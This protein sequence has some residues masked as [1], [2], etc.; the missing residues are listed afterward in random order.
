MTE[1]ARRYVVPGR[2]ELVGKHVDYAGGRSLTCAVDRA[3]TVEAR[4][5]D[6]PMVRVRDASRRGVVQ[7]PLLAGVERTHRSARWSAYV[8]AVARR[9]ARDFPQA[10]SGVELHVSSTL[11]PSAGLSSSSAL[12]VAIASA[13]ADAN[14]LEDD[15]RWRAAVP[16]DLAR[17]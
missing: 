15:E 7:V 1:P 9:F 13:L 6:E 8:V 2:V 3:I 17:A 5:L 11:P 14:R 16:T 12:V 10:R 4:P